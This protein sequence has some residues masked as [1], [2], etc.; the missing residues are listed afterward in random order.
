MKIHKSA[1]R[2]LSILIFTSIIPLQHIAHAQA[3][4]YV[5]FIS[6]GQEVPPVTTRALS[7]G[8]FSFL[9]G[10]AA[11]VGLR[12]NRNHDQVVTA[13]HIHE[14][15]V[16]V[17]GAVIL[18]MRPTVPAEGFCIDLAGGAITYY[19]LTAEALRGSLAGGTLTDLRVLMATGDTYINLHTDIYPGGWIRGQMNPAVP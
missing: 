13:I 11:L 2:L 15:P 17:D 18:N 19:V 8:R 16:G 5:T 1:I 6:G 3:T 9:E 12:I 4:D 7:I 10:D 14:G